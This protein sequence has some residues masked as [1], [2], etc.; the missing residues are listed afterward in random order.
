[1]KDYNIHLFNSFYGNYHIQDTTCKHLSLSQKISPI[2]KDFFNRIRNA[3]RSKLEQLVLSYTPVL[4][5]GISSGV[6]I[7]NL[8]DQKIGRQDDQEENSLSHIAL[9]MAASGMLLWGYGALRIVRHF[10]YATSLFSQTSKFHLLLPFISEVFFELKREN[11]DLVD[12]WAQINDFTNEQDILKF[13]EMELKKGACSGYVMAILEQLKDGK[14]L[15]GDRLLKNLNIKT[16]IKKQLFN[17]FYYSLNN[18]LETNKEMGELKR[19]IIQTAANE[20]L[21]LFYHMNGSFKINTAGPSIDISAGPSKIKEFFLHQLYSHPFQDFDQF[22][23]ID[24]SD[25]MRSQFDC[26]K[27][28]FFMHRENFC[29]EQNHFYKDEKVH[30]NFVSFLQNDFIIAGEI[31]MKRSDGSHHDIYFRLSNRKYHFFDP[32]EAF[33]ELPTFAKFFD[34]VYQ[35]IADNSGINTQICF[36]ILAIEPDKSNINNIKY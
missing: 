13:L 2:V 1:M 31:I 30:K 25:C 9:G 10:D 26:F 15:Q 23:D 6:M 14:E 7:A 16:V 32:N 8:F 11:R 35:S 36:R 21:R 28:E 22:Q 17:D 19:S 34:K 20:S 4:L 29:P 12:L 27:T 5:T 18:F 24:P 3:D 33:F